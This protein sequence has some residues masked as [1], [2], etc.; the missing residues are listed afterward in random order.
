[1]RIPAIVYAPEHHQGKLPAIV[2]VPGHGGDKTTWYSIYTG[3]LYAKAGA[4]V[5]TYDPIGEDERNADRRSDAR[6]HDTVIAGRN[7]PVRTGGL[8]LTDILQAVSYLS[9]IPYVDPTRIAVAGYSMGS[10]QSALAAAIDPRIRVLILSGGGNLDGN[11]GSWDTENKP[12]CQA[13]L[14]IA[15]SFLS[16]KGAILYALHQRVGP[17]LILNGRLDAL[18]GRPHHFE[19][20]FADLS[21]RVAG[22]A[23]PAAPCLEFRFLPNVGHRPSWVTLDAAEWLNAQ[24][25]FSNWAGVSLSSLGE[26]HIAEWAAATGVHINTGYTDEVREGGIRA[27]GTGLPGIPRD[28]LQVVPESDWHRH[29]DL[30]IWQSWQKH[31]LEAAD[32]PLSLAAT[33][34][35]PR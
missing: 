3:L 24:L 1:M 28:Q 18:V 35:P 27:L 23:G 14:Y 15:L 34:P 16:D 29:K 20:F 32:L 26:T 30:Y 9:R 10:L 5:L 12:M 8:M 21:D 33:P 6:A 13:S 31:L 2:V 11:G 4:V 19:N 7:S 22:L 17:T 25:H